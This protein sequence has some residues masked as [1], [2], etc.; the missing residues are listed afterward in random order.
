LVNGKLALSEERRAIL[1]VAWRT[2]ACLFE[3]GE[4][5]LSSTLGEVLHAL[6]K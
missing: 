1:S 6:L 2:L 4:S 3:F 5:L